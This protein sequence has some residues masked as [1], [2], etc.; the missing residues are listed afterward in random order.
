MRDEL[1]VLPPGD[2]LKCALA[3][4]RNER[5]VGA[6]RKLGATVIEK[7]FTL[8]RVDDDLEKPRN[9][10]PRS[11]DG[12]DQELLTTRAFPMPATEGTSLA[13]A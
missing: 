5:G 2:V 3:L 6:M 9:D 1:G 8:S 4:A 13:S 7:H 11:N 10:E 12:S